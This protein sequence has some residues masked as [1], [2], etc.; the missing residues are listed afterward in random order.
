MER[1]SSDKLSPRFYGPYE[2]IA[3]VGNVSYTLRLPE[4]VRI[5]PTFHVSLLKRCP[6]PL[7][8]PVHPSEGMSK[9]HRVREPTMVL[10]RRLVQRKGRAVTKVLIH[11]KV[12]TWQRHHGKTGKMFKLDFLSLQRHLT[13]ED[14]GDVIRGQCKD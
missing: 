5:H 2:I 1:R 4:G 8:T 11:W 7:L 12:K 9:P 10:Y 13:L 6:N 14:K 3:K